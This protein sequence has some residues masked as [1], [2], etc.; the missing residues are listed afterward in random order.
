M[1][2]APNLCPVDLELLESRLAEGGEPRFRAD[3]VWEWTARG[4][5]SYEE[6]TNLPGALR[7]RLGGGRPV[8]GACPSAT[9][10]RARRE[11]RERMAGEPVCSRL[12]FVA[13]ALARDGTEKAL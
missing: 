2:P 10:P 4:A 13:E 11:R 3:Q 8:R 6:M 12:E 7:E 5:G 1:P 9:T